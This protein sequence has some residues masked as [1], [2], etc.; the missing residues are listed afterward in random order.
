M[1]AS[2]EGIPVAS[3]ADNTRLSFRRGRR[4]PLLEE[5]IE[6]LNSVGASCLGV[7]L[8]Y[9][10][11]ADCDRYVSKSSLSVPRGEPDKKAGGLEARSP[12]E[13]RLENAKHSALIRAM[14]DASTQT[15]AHRVEPQ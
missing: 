4:R 14:S 10:D 11:Q 6:R 15:R 2:L 5:C 3:A 9:A 7:V 12:D 1:L 13:P 8:N